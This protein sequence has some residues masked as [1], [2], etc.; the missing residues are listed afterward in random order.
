MS[1]TDAGRSSTGST[2]RRRLQA[3]TIAAV[4]LTVIAT[5]MA[6][7]QTTQAGLVPQA[8]GKAPAIP[9]G[10][11]AAAAPASNAKLSLSVALA[12]RNQAALDAF[13]QQVSD[14]KSPQYKHYLGKGQFGGVFGATQQ[15]IDS[16]TK[17]LKDA[18]LTPGA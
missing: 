17:A 3:A 14:P 16:V 11:V 8:V 13:V 10:A 4:S 2:W 9:H 15:T 5:P 18:G 7:A 6:S 12:P 1:D